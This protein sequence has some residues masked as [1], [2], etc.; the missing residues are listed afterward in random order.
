MKSVNEI[1]RGIREDRDL[2]QS[3]IALILGIAQQY[4]SKYE[5]GEYDLPIRHLI[6]LSEYYDVTTDYL[7]G[8]TSYKGNLSRLAE[9]L[10]DAI[11]CGDLISSIMCLNTNE[12][13]SVI[14]YIQLMKIKHELDKNK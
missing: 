4:Y 8:K 1:I 11:S 7:L 6:K 14:E 9:P 2:K 3:D 13:K 5:T 10:V 12:K